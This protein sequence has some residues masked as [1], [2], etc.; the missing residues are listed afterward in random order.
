MRSQRARSSAAYAASIT[1]TEA[2]PSSGVTTRRLRAA[3]RAAE[4]VELI[5]ERL[6][7]V[8]ALPEDVPVALADAG[9]SATP[10][11]R[12]GSCRRCRRCRRKVSSSLSMLHE[13]S[14]VP[15]TPSSLWTKRRTVSSTARPCMRRPSTTWMSRRV[16]QEIAQ[17]VDRVR[18]VVDEHA[19]AA[20]RGVGVPA[21]AHV[22]ERRERVLAKT[23]SPISPDAK[24]SRALRT[25]AA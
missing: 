16:A 23:S 13:R 22:D 20:D 25:S 12:R 1:S 9:G 14:A 11:I 6:D 21:I 4:V 10:S 24:S 5:A 18:A 7:L 19:A 17:D 3:N 15:I 2:S 8:V